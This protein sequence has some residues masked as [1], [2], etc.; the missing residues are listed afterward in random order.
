VV[1]FHLLSCLLTLD[2]DNFRFIQ[3]DFVAD[4]GLL[5]IIHI[6]FR[7]FWW[8]S[9]ISIFRPTGHNFSTQQCNL[10]LGLWSVGAERPSNRGGT[11]NVPENGTE[12][13]RLGRSCGSIRGGSTLGRIDR[14]PSECNALIHPSYYS[15]PNTSSMS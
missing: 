5:L 8:I 15:N 6:G 4:G 11:W 14:K 12:R 2:L 13:P 3:M 9:W 10:Y 7:K 1:L